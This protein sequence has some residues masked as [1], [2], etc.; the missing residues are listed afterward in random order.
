[1]K[2]TL[3][4]F[5]IVVL[6]TS[7]MSIQVFASSV[8]SSFGD[9]PKIDDSAIKIDGLIDEAAWN[10]AVK[11]PIDRLSPSSAAQPSAERSGATGT[12]Y[13]MWGDKGIYFGIKITDPT[14]TNADSSTLTVDV[15]FYNTDNIEIMLDPS[16]S[17]NIEKTPCYQVNN[18]GFPH[19]GNVENGQTLMG[20]DCDKYMQYAATR[21]SDGYILEILAL[22]NNA[23]GTFTAGQKIGISFQITDMSDTDLNNWGDRLIV[24]SP[25]SLGSEVDGWSVEQFDYIILA[26][27][28]EVIPPVDIVADNPADVPADISENVPAV[29]TPSPNTR[30]AFAISIFMIL[31]VVTA[32][33]VSKKIK[34]AK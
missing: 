4:I 28:P 6:L 27:L 5:F 26:D 23:V 10:N 8:G 18:N 11:I 21:T 31:T 1:M 15:P 22:N 14:Y 17:G 13:I 12:A 25:A 2:K 33:V 34:T 19:M 7:I 20:A 30:D 9:V 3:S 32:I 24:L 16:N 29:N